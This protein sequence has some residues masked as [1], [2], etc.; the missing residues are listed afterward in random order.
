MKE[1]VSAYGASALQFLYNY[2]V[3]QG[4]YGGGL[5]PLSQ[6]IETF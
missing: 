2:A 5:R 1:C 4:A 3:G 6:K